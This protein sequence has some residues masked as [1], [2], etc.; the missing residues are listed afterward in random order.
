MESAYE[1]CR[2]LFWKTI[3]LSGEQLDE[4]GLPSLNSRMTSDSYN[5]QSFIQ[6]GQSMG[7]RAPILIVVIVF[8]SMKGIPLYE[9]AQQCLDGIV[10]VMRE[11]ITCIR[12]VKALSKE[13]SEIDRFGRRNEEKTKNDIKAGII[14]ALPGPKYEGNVIPF[15]RVK[16]RIHLVSR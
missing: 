1:I 9:K 4:I 7:I 6:R 13:E 2:D 3:N 10:R 11:N 16:G 15:V 8:V 14:M 12:V 5:V